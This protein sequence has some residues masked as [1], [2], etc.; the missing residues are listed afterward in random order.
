MTD[1]RHWHQLFDSEHPPTVSIATEL[2]TR[3]QAWLPWR[4][5]SEEKMFRRAQNL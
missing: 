3:T 1:N 2:Q 4:S 5:E